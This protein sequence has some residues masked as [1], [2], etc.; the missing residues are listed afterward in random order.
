MGCGL[1]LFIG[2]F[3]IIFTGTLAQIKGYAILLL[4]IAGIDFIIRLIFGISLMISNKNNNNE[5]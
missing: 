3:V 1:L 4:I 2:L 5:E